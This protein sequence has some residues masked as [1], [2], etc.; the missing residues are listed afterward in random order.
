MRQS[1]LLR[2]LHGQLAGFFVER[3][4]HGQHDRVLLETDSVSPRGLRRIVIPG[5][6][7][8]R[9]ERRRRLHRRQARA[10]LCSPG[11]QRS[12]AIH[13]R[14]RQPGLGRRDLPCR[15]R[16]LPGL[17]RRLR[18]RPLACRSRAGASVRLLV[19]PARSESRGTRE[20]SADARNLAGRCKLRHVEDADR[21]AA[22]GSM[23]AP[24][25]SSRDRCRRA[26][27]RER[28]SLCRGSRMFSSSFQRWLRSRATHH[29]SIV[30]TSV[31]LLSRVTGTVAPS[32]PSTCSVT[33]RELSS[34]RS[35]P[36][37]SINEPDRIVLAD[38]GAEEPELG[39]FADRQREFER[40]DR[41]GGSFL[42]PER[43][44]AEGLDGRRDPRHGRHGALDADVV[45]ACGAAANPD[46]PAS[47]REAV[48]RRRRARRRDRD[49]A[50]PERD[51]RR[52]PRSPPA[53]A[54][55]SAPRRHGRGVPSAFITP[56]L[57]RTWVGQ[58]SP[59]GPRRIGDA[60]F[61]S[62]VWRERKR[63]RCRVT[64]GSAA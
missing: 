35:S 22:T 63:A 19:V 30:P 31:I 42:H 49:P 46:A 5:V 12:R 7:Q 36:Q 1:R 29:S 55:R 60:R 64:A 4:R 2:R 48:V 34:S 39:G 56:P 59:L 51:A 21:T 57:K 41:R 58:A 54:I 23:R 50:P 11:Q 6:A 26:A 32:W 43:D 9:Q 62:L 61:A 45:G 8:V 53:S 24:S 16:A 40:R 10:F 3:R 33:S 15:G 18:R 25:S 13:R 47:A 38:C 44:D 20:A 17:G 52:A 28:I 14:V 27:S 37:S